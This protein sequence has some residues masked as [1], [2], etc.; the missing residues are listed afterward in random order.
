MTTIDPTTPL[1]KARLKCGDWADIPLLPDSVYNATLADTNNNVNQTAQTCGMYILGMLSGKT[2]KKLAQLETW[3]SDQFN[4]YMTYLNM[5]VKD[6]SF[7]GVCPIPYNGDSTQ[8]N[9]FQT[10]HDDWVAGYIPG[11]VVIPYGAFPGTVVPPV[12]IVNDPT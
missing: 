5:M 10:L 4:Q 7:S 2:H 3:G 11:T 12:I 6:P 8:T 9:P 1:G